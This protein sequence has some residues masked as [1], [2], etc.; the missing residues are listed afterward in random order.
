MGTGVI[1]LRTG[2]HSFLGQNP[3]LQARLLQWEREAPEEVKQEIG[4]LRRRNLEARIEAVTQLGK[5]GSKGAIPPLIEVFQVKKAFERRP[6]GS[7]L[8]E[9]VSKALGTIGEPAVEPL[10]AALKDKDAAVRRGAAMT[11]G[12][13]PDPRAVEP[14][15]A[16]LKDMDGRVRL[17]A[18]GALGKIKDPRAVEPL[19]ADLK[20]ENASVR[21][22]ARRVLGEIGEPAVGPL[23]TAL[24]DRGV[25]S[26]AF[27]TLVAIG[28]PAVEL[29]LTALKDDDGEVRE[30]AA[31]ALQY[32]PD[33][34][35]VGPLIDAL[36]DKDRRETHDPARIGLEKITDPRA[37][38]PFLAAL[39]D[40]DSP[41]VREVAA[42]ALGNIK[43]VRAVGPLRTAL[44]DKDGGVRQ[45]AAEALR[46]IDESKINR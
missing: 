12:K 39:K 10:L 26:E 8:A 31:M 4:L 13:I 5:M 25:R 6:D 15:L 14:L 33:P 44:K 19:I 28:E 45:A 42:K 18:E 9:S 16:A 1:I 24:K 23:V 43:D 40:M 22:A 11:L 7:C 30:A 17:E 27:Y 2:K 41:S 3:E 37:A 38:E 32:I 46:K 20:D 36:K 21:R 29:L 34:R 35:S